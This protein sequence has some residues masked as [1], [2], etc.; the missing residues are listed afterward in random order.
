MYDPA[1]IPRPEQD[2]LGER[3]RQLEGRT[4]DQVWYREVDFQGTEEE[5]KEK[6]LPLWKRGEGYEEVFMNFYLVTGETTFR[7]AHTG[8]MRMRGLDVTSDPEML[9]DAADEY[10]L[11]ND[12]SEASGWQPFVGKRIAEA[13]LF[14]PWMDYEIGYWQ[15]PRDLGLT[16]ED[17]S[18]VYV[19]TGALDEDGYEMEQLSTVF[20]EEAAR[21][22]GVGPHFASETPPEEAV[23][24]PREAPS[25][26][27]IEALSAGGLIGETI[28]QVWRGLG[29]ADK[30]ERKRSTSR[31]R[32]QGK[33][34]V[35]VGYEVLP[36]RL[37]F[38][39]E[40]H[41]FYLSWGTAPRYGVW[42]GRD[43]IGDNVEL[44][45]LSEEEA[46]SRLVGQRVEDVHC[47]WHTFDDGQAQLCIPRDLEIVM[48]DGHRLF[49][50][51]ANPDKEEDDISYLHQL[52]V[53]HGERAAW[54]FQIGPFADGTHPTGPV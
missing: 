41:T 37:Y 5:R 9:L 27:V 40:E 43:F 3:V 39:T 44:E 2:V 20:G 4:I 48:E 26:W 49:L 14:W 52:T 45:E 7:F 23:R 32:E 11:L 8:A 36:L 13:R 50:S 16:F 1:R 33:P 22:Y 25:S 42:A 18:T 53:Y 28:Q 21:A 54:Q 17:G 34:D 38:A 35:P 47:Y 6:G 19:T 12:V 29:T 31:W 24:I 10:G 46:W 51:A 30:R 15:C